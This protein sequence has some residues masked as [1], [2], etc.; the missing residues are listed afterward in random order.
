[1]S[2]SANVNNSAICTETKKRH[3][4]LGHVGQQGLLE[5]CKQGLLGKKKPDDLFFCETCVLAKQHRQ[6]FPKGIHRAKTRLEYI[7]ADLWGPENIK[8]M[9]E[10]NT[11]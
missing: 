5:L 7:H 6:K 3:L 4:R 8:H 9:G 10:I 11:F 1:M 2:M